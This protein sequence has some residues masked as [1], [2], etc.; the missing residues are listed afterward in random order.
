MTIQP[1]FKYADSAFLF[2]QH[3]LVFFVK[4]VAGLATKCAVKDTFWSRKGGFNGTT[5]T[6][7][8]HIPNQESH[9]RA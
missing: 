2:L 9:Q 5:K 1:A 4:F 3:S 7:K 8:T 6:M